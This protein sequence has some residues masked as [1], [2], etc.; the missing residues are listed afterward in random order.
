[1]AA[2]PGGYMY[3]L[4]EAYRCGRVD[5]GNQALLTRRQLFSDDSCT[6]DRRRSV[7]DQHRDVVDSTLKSVHC[8][9]VCAAHQRTTIYLQTAYDNNN[10]NT[11]YQDK[12]HLAPSGSKVRPGCGQVG[13]RY[14]RR[15]HGDH[16]P[17]SAIVSGFAKRELIQSRFRTRSQPAVKPVMFSC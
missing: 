3:R 6:V 7:A 10:N 13:G 5:G 12:R 9:R 2:T 14:Y 11:T 17:V 16:R 15:L 8:L 1:M 4:S